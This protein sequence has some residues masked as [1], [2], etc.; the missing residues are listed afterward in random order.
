MKTAIKG[1][2]EGCWPKYIAYMTQPSCSSRKKES[3]SISELDY[4]G[5]QQQEENLVTLP[6]SPL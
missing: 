3:H 1:Q 4:T 2:K 5:S 6:G